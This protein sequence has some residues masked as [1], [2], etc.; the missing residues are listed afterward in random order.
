MQA[1][2]DLDSRQPTKTIVIAHV[3]PHI[4][5]AAHSANTLSYAA[6]FR[7]VAPKLAASPTP[8]GADPR[9]WDHGHSINYLTRGLQHELGKVLPGHDVSKLPVDL[10]AFLPAPRGGLNLCKMYGAEW[11]SG[12]LKASE[13]EGMKQKRL[14]KAAFAVY[15]AFSERL[16]V[17]RTQGRK[18][19]F[20]RADQSGYRKLTCSASGSNA[21]CSL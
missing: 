3:S 8:N 21:D 12:M 14:E 10:E 20:T 18:E 1:L 13:W 9:S 11:V 15:V 6:P 7:S 2:F 19:L 16:R 5:D 4:Q 17:A